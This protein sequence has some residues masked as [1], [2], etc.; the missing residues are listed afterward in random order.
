MKRSFYAPRLQDEDAHAHLFF[1]ASAASGIDRIVK[2]VVKGFFVR[3]IPI[4]VIKDSTTF[5]FSNG[6]NLGANSSSKNDKM[7]SDLNDIYLMDGKEGGFTTGEY[8][9]LGNSTTLNIDPEDYI[10]Y[11]SVNDD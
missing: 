10:I 7:H 6:V 11:I 3:I 5:I 1:R 2:A 4:G 8:Q 9:V